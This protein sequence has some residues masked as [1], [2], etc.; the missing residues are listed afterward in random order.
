[1]NLLWFANWNRAG[2]NSRS[3]MAKAIRDDNT[4]MLGTVV[5]AACL[6]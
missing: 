1:M 6:L 4:G 5:I 3:L 2:E